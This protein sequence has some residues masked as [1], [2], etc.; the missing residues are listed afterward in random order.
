MIIEGV[1]V[2]RDASPIRRNA[3][4][5]RPGVR[6]AV[7]A[8][9]AY[10]LF[11]SREL[12]QATIVRA[13]SSP[14]VVDVLVAQ[15]LDVAAGVRQQLEADVRRVPGLRVVGEHFMLIEQAMGTPRKRDAAGV[16]YLHAY[17]EAMKTSGFVAA[18]LARHGIEG[19]AI[20][21]AS[22]PRRAGSL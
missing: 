10:D 9:S 20:A 22:D 5:D 8:G 18:A 6:V 7:G 14:L 13:P 19:A 3:E 1:Y 16:E 21:P 4:V 17:V 12:K 2:V 11:L 15:G